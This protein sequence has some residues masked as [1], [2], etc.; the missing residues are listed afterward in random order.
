MRLFFPSNFRQLELRSWEPTQAIRSATSDLGDLGLTAPERRRRA[1]LPRKCGE[2][3]EGSL[4]RKP[5]LPRPPGASR[6]TRIFSADLDKGPIRGRPIGV[7]NDQDTPTA[8]TGFGPFA[9]LGQISPCSGR[10][11]KRRSGANALSALGSAGGSVTIPVGVVLRSATPR[12]RSFSIAIVH[13]IYHRGHREDEKEQI[14][15]NLPPC[16]LWALWALWLR[17]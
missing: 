12:R 15:Q 13:R 3:K 14:P 1:K 5:H 17:R 2:P 8:L 11:G 9:R 6:V 4:R 16:S 10:W 7:G